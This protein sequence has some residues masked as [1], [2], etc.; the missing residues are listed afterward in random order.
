[1]ASKLRR[2]DEVEF[3]YNEDLSVTVLQKVQPG[4]ER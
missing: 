2:D 3:V 4:V 1:V